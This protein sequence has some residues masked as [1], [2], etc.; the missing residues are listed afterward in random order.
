MEYTPALMPNAPFANATGGVVHAWRP[1]HWFTTQSEIGTDSLTHKSSNGSNGSD[2]SDGSG[3]GTAFE[4]GTFVWSKGGGQGSEGFDSNAEW[5]IE[6]ILEL[7]DF[8]GE[9]FF[10]ETTRLLYYVDNATDPTDPTDPTGPMDPTDPTDAAPTQ[11]FVATQTQTLFNIS[12]GNV[13]DFAT[14]TKEAPHQ[15]QHQHANSGHGSTPS[16]VQL[17]TNI[18]LRGIELRDTAYTYLEPHGLPSSGDWALQHTAA[19]SIRD[20]EGVTIEGCLMTRLDGLGIL[21]N[22]YSRNV[23]IENNEFAHLGRAHYAL[24]CTTR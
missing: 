19:V 14:S 23:T 22:G 11:E 2:G 6:N 12:G 4:N 15:H 7:C 10:N 20:A 18:K 24:Y 9:F 1:A 5:W 16:G 13:A 8:P 3:S 21:V 17:V